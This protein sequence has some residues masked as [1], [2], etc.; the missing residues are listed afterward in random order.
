MRHYGFLVSALIVLAAC[1]NNDAGSGNSRYNH[2]SSSP[3]RMSSDTLCYR[4]AG[5]KENPEVKA[6]I[7]ARGL[8]CRAI[9]ENDPLMDMGRY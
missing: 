1:S 2:P 5:A 6:E 9:L 7:K 4:A 8:D 3:S